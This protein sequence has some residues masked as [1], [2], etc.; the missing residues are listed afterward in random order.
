LPGYWG[1]NCEKQWTQEGCGISQCSHH[2]TCGCPTANAQNCASTN[3]ATTCSCT[4]GWGDCQCNSTVTNH[5][6]QDAPACQHGGVCTSYQGGYGCTCLAGYYGARCEFYDNG[7]SSLNPC[8]NGG[9]CSLT[10]AWSSSTFQVTKGYEVAVCDCVYPYYGVHCENKADVDNLCY[11]SNPCQNGGNCTVN[12]W[13]RGYWQ[14]I[15]GYLNNQRQEQAPYVCA[16]APGFYGTTC[17]TTTVPTPVTL[18]TCTNTPTYC[19]NGGTCI[20]GFPNPTCSCICGWSGDQCEIAAT[21]ST[22][23]LSSTLQDFCGST[24]VCYNGGTCY[25]SANGQGFFCNCQAGFWGTRCQNAGK[26]A[27]SAAL[28]SLLITALAILVALKAKF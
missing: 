28:P 15:G 20:D 25:N 8:Q 19:S 5:C 12:T 18:P 9:R 27:A 4:G 21:S 3:W 7:C 2:G 16:C 26:S 14:V 6:P 22:K 24:S 1:L 17:Q 11:T 23:G 10:R 13:D